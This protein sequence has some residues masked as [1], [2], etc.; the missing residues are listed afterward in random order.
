MDD[1][2]LDTQLAAGTLNAQGDFSAVGDEDFP[3]HGQ[4]VS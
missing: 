3:E 4:S 1:H 2:G